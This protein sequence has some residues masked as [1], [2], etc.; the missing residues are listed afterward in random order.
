M[1]CDDADACLTEV[2]NER[3]AMF[4]WCVSLLIHGRGGV[5]IFVQVLLSPYYPV[6]FADLQGGGGPDFCDNSTSAMKVQQEHSNVT[7]YWVKLLIIVCLLSMPASSTPYNI[8]TSVTLSSPLPSLSSLS[9]S[10]KMS[11]CLMAKLWRA[12][13]VTMILLALFGER[14]SKKCKY[15]NQP[16]SRPI[17]LSTLLRQDACA[18]LNLSWDGVSAPSSRNAFNR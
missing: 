12:Q 1:R 2:W 5:Q 4:H 6:T 8:S 18:L 3:K 15:R 16:F 14:T 17:P 13:H 9:S 10:S 11:P 7:S